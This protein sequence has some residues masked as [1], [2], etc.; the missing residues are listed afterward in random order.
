MLYKNTTINKC[1]IRVPEYLIRWGNRGQPN[2][3]TLL[4]NL[5]D[6]LLSLNCQWHRSFQ[7][8]VEW[9]QFRDQRGKSDLT[10]WLQGLATIQLTVNI[11]L[12]LVFS[13]CLKVRE[14]GQEVACASNLEYFAHKGLKEPEIGCEIKAP[15]MSI[16]LW[17]TSRI[18][19]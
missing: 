1:H 11:N 10:A 19:I 3:S 7:Q 13:I 8:K 18:A 12:I 16:S 6:E 14:G 15:F 9:A 2:I 17:E 5:T 4:T